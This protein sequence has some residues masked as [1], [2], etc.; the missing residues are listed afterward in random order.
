[1]ESSK[2]ESTPC[3]SDAAACN[4]AASVRIP[5]ADPDP[6]SYTDQNWPRFLVIKSCDDKSILKHNLFVIAKAIEGIAGKPKEVKALKNAGLLLIEVDKKHHAINLLKAKQL[7]DIPVNISAHR[8][9]NSSKGVFTCHHLD[10]YDDKDVLT[11]L[12]NSDQNIK[13]MYRIMTYK[14]GSQ[15][16]TNTFVVTFSTKTLPDKIYV[17]HYRVKVRIFIPN[18]RRCTNCQQFHHTKK[19]CKNQVTCSKCG[20][21]G[22]DDRSCNLDAT[23]VNCKGSHKASSKECPV[24]KKEKE[25]M[26]YKYENDVSFLDARK[27]VEESIKSRSSTTYATAVSNIPLKCDMGIQ[28]DLT[29]PAFL[30]SPVLTTESI[31]TANQSVQ[32]TNEMESE[33]SNSKRTRS[34]SSSSNNEENSS[35]VSKN[36]KVRVTSGD[37]DVHRSVVSPSLGGVST[38]EWKGGRGARK[39]RPPDR[40]PNPISR[41][42]S[43]HTLRPGDRDRSPIKLP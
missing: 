43:S 17:G 22:H 24:W 6:D 3:S 39:S 18:P 8:T 42:R 40:T 5:V 33:S 10:D 36:S 21:T 35:N 26:Q 30:T 41:S 32:A 25:I 14:N 16:K 7:H 38:S 12:K 9:M 27:K 13:E 28:T 37:S 11:V 34:N 31:M 4:P 23:C 20:Q 2:K 1:M 29:W 15:A 19:F